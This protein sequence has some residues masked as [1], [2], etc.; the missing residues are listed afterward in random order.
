[1]S[2]VDAEAASTEPFALPEA[3][4]STAPAVADGRPGRAEV[5]VP[6]RDIEPVGFVELVQP[7]VEGAMGGVVLYGPRDERLDVVQ[8][9]VSFEPQRAARHTAEPPVGVVS[10]SVERMTDAELR[11]LRD[12][13]TPEDLYNAIA[14]NAPHTI[15][16]CLQSMVVPPVFVAREEGR[17][18]VIHLLVKHN[19][20]PLMNDFAPGFAAHP[21]AAKQA[22]PNGNT[23]MHLAAAGGSQDMVAAL[24]RIGCVDPAGGN[25][26]HQTPLQY[27][28]EH[29]ESEEAVV[30]VLEVL[31]AS[32]RDV[33]VDRPDKETITALHR[34][35]QMG[36]AE[37]A[38]VLL[39]AGAGVAPKSF[40]GATPL[41]AASIEGHGDVCTVLLNYGAPT[42]VRD[43]RGRT[44]LFCAAFLGRPDAVSALLECKTCDVN[45]LTPHGYT[46]VEAAAAKPTAGHRRCVDMLMARG[47]RFDR[48]TAMQQCCKNVVDNKNDL[49]GS[50]VVCKPCCEHFGCVHK[51]R[52][53]GE[54]SHVFYP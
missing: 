8:G 39:E 28:I 23:A 48:P 47:S 25:G 20:V 43:K 51:S 9:R 4:A 40:R 11:I 2:G 7:A 21:E 44:P 15:A 27:A 6:Q 49:N 13:A 3:L 32:H 19:L 45:A 33:G 54:L 22:D 12:G 29:G 50:C 36:Y 42:E 30:G 1:M 35:A 52:R 16:L 34:A 14:D 53:T 10:H 17:A 38:R 26:R 18:S 24:L 31:L 37:A 46:P 41:H 5:V